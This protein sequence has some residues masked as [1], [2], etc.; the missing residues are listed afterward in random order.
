MISK[1]IAYLIVASILSAGAFTSTAN[2]AEKVE[3][4]NTSPSTL[5]SLT[6]K[7]NVNAGLLEPQGLSV[8][9]FVNNTRWTLH[10]YV[11]GEYKGVVYPNH[12]LPVYAPSGYVVLSARV[13][14]VNAP[15]LF[16]N[17]GWLYYYPG[18]TYTWR[19]TA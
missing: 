11:N 6:P 12:Y 14:F 4:N 3:F 17:S 1:A 16:W 9:S 8:V 5:V 15:S 2:A 10:C 7:A 19:L 13:D 18:G